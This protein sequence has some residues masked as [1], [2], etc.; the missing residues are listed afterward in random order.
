MNNIWRQPVN[1]HLRKAS[2]L[3]ELVE[4][5]IAPLTRAG[6]VEAALFHLNLA[7]SYFLREIAENY[8]VPESGA[9]QV[10]DDLSK[11]L[12]RID[13]QPPE[14]NEILVA[15]N[16]GWIRDMHRAWQKLHNYSAKSASGLAMPA[17]SLIQTRQL[18]DDELNQEQMQTW[19]ARMRELV[20]RQREMMV[21]C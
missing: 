15:A 1:A 9:I 4:P 17:T 3:L 20:E 8:Q 18:S 5:G 11:A 19:T 12:A 2:A 6:L 13:K 7:L 10:A 16:K 21:E 14:L